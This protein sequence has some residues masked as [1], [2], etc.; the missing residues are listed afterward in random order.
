MGDN[1]GSPLKGSLVVIQFI[2]QMDGFGST[3][4]FFTLQHLS[5]YPSPG[6]SDTRQVVSHVAKVT[7]S[8]L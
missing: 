3:G 7:Y 4:K 1:V 5:L 8:G 6:Q 2:L